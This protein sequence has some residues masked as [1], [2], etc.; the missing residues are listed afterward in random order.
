MSRTRAS[1]L[2]AVAAPAV[3]FSL[4]CAAPAALAATAPAATAAPTATSFTDRIKVDWVAPADGGSPILSYNLYSQTGNVTALA[5]TVPAGATTAVLPQSALTGTSAVLTVKAVNAVGEGGGL[6]T[7]SGLAADDWPFIR[8][9]GDG[10]GELDLGRATFTGLPQ[11]F[12]GFAPLDTAGDHVGLAMTRDQSRLVFGVR[13]TPGA[14]L[15]LYT[16]PADSSAGRSVLAAEAGVEES[17]PTWAPDGSAVIYTRGTGASAALYRVPVTGGIAAGPAVPVT[18]G[19]GLADAEWA[20]AGGFL[21]ARPST[22]TGPLVQLD[23]T[24]GVRTAVPGTG[25]AVTL[26]ISPRA[27]AVAYLTTGTGPT[28]CL[29]LAVLGRMLPVSD[30]GCY[31]VTAPSR[32][33]VVWDPDGTALWAPI[34]TGTVAGVAI[35]Q[36]PNVNGSTGELRSVQSVSQSAQPLWFSRRYRVRHPAVGLL[37]LPAITSQH[38]SMPFTAPI[39]P[40]GSRYPVSCAVDTGAAQACTSP[41]TA[42]VAPG[43]RSLGFSVVGGA[44]SWTWTARPE[45]RGTDRTGDGRPDLLAQD[46]A[47]RVW[48]YPSTATGFATRRLFAAL[49]PSMRLAAGTTA[50]Y[51]DPLADALVK[52]TPTE[53]DVVESVPGAV[54]QGL[55]STAWGSNTLT[56]SPGDWDSDGTFDLLARDTLG[57]LWLYP[58]DSGGF[59]TGTIGYGPRRQV[60]SGWGGFRLLVAP[61]DLD[62]DHRPDLLAVNGAGVLLLYRGKGDGTVFP[63]R[64]VGTGWGQYNTLVGPGDWDLDG[65]VDLLARNAAGQL[66][67]YSGTGT[68]SLRPRRQLSGSWAAFTVLAA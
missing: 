7:S 28:G 53:L 1:L 39:L 52:S 12:A 16:L 63:S 14:D 27:D 48:T 38:I 57:R 45:S 46:S 30:L 25:G 9:R 22:G 2:A 44:G 66:F 55:V 24:T 59:V 4:L 51:D 13:A 20:A 37:G 68:G 17:H 34:M 21:V 43:T 31:Q 54:T 61:G 6:P 11:S 62:G 26:A 35:A 8:T 50:D 40:D 15:D 23:L 33:S 65:R 64:Q 41:F 47:G 19:A 3:L 29:R 58:G 36:R 60:G 32:M 67:L 42:F 49:N 10:T 5:A 56:L 18:N